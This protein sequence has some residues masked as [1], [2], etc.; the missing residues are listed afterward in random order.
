MR[1]AFIDTKKRKQVEGLLRQHYTEEEVQSLIENSL[2]GVWYASEG[3]STWVET[4]NPAE[5]TKTIRA[6]HAR[7]VAITQTQ[8]DDLVTRE[9][10]AQIQKIVEGVPTAAKHIIPCG[11]RRAL[12]V[13]LDFQQQIHQAWDGY[14]TRPIT[15]PPTGVGYQ[16]WEFTS[17]GSPISPVFD[18]PE[19]LARWLSDTQASA[20]GR[21]TAQYDTWLQWIHD[22]TG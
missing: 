11:S 20:F 3:E 21:I 1:T 2:T 8:R 13:P 12:R 16:M 19:G 18:T 10:I 15:P 17:E 9:M 6:C 22:D 7:A 4:A 14:K 5:I